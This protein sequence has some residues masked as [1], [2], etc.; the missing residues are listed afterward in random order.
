MGVSSL[1]RELNADA[2]ADAF[3]LAGDAGEMVLI[4]R[5]PPWAEFLPGGTIS[6][7]T[8]DTTAA[9]IEAVQAND[10]DLFF[11]IDPTD[12]AT[13]RDRL[14]SLP[15]ELEGRG[16][17]DTDVRSAFL[18]YAEYVAINYEPAYLALAV[19]INLY[20]ARDES[21]IES[22]AS[23]YAE[24]Y[25]RLKEVAP[26]TQIT[27]TLQYEDLQSLLPTEDRHFA[28]WGLLERFDE[29]MD[30]V[31]LSTYPGLVF[32]RTEDIPANYYS[33]L[34]GFTE[35]SIVIADT[36]FPSAPSPTSSTGSPEEQ[37]SFLERI[38][39]EAQDM[40]MPFVIWLAAWDPAYAEGT[41]F[42]SF[43]YVGLLQSD[44]TEKPAWSAWMEEAG[45]SLEAE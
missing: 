40:Q 34:Q 11:A 41:A 2:Y 37:T 10:L 4:R 16:F 45:R 12:P 21:R 13:G 1:P 25:D 7:D 9:E 14:A 23:L 15:Q 19:E 29:W 17:E 43:R 3:D 30:V 36:G 5:A 31:A 33:Q 39:G 38:V 28:D 27:V 6:T 32:S 24:T 35:K 22:F 44:G 18:S 26:D 20:I 42:D 8:A